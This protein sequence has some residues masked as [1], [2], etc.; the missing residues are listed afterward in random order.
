MKKIFLICLLSTLS[1]CSSDFMVNPAFSFMPQNVFHDSNSPKQDIIEYKY[2]STE[3]IEKE[4]IKIGI[5]ESLNT[6]PEYIVQ[7]FTTNY[8]C[9]EKNIL[10][11]D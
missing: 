10:R 3:K 8:K 6:N 4:C 11:K 7:F 9:P 5:W 1:F 2:W